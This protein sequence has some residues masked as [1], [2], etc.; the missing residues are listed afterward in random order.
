M[1][2]KLR[3]PKG[4]PESI[5]SGPPFE[6]LQR[7]WAKV[8]FLVL[9]QDLLVAFNLFRGLRCFSPQPI[10]LL[11]T[12]VC[13]PNK[14]G[15]PPASPYLFS[16]GFPG[17]LSVNFRYEPTTLDVLDRLLS[18]PIRSPLVP[19]PTLFLSSPARQFG[20]NSFFRPQ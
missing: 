19:G 3:P 6:H 11:G 5:A 4:P 8:A 14:P 20:P 12:A 7:A 13:C 2:P 16:E 9:A 10:L 18:S 17:Y 15:G 1:T